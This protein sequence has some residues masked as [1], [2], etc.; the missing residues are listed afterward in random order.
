M[1]TIHELGQ[2]DVGR[3]IRIGDEVEGEL[4]GYSIILNGRTRKYPYAFSYCIWL[5]AKHGTFEAK[6]NDCRVGFEY[7]DE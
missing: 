3:R 1:K 4:V 7:L 5:D 2:L 6:Y